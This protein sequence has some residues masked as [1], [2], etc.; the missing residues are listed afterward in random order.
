M[1]IFDR[2]GTSGGDGVSE[3]MN[4]TLPRTTLGGDATGPAPDEPV[5]SGADW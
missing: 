3:V 4:E 5:L 2:G 1:M